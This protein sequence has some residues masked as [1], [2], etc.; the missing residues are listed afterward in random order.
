VTNRRHAAP[1]RRRI[2]SLRPLAFLAAGLIVLWASSAYGYWTASSTG[3]YALANAATLPSPTLSAASVTATSAALSWTQPFVPTGYALT[4]STGSLTGCTAAPA[5]GS[6]SCTATSLTPN[7]SYSWQLTASLY[8]WQAPATVS[9]TTAKQATTTALSNLT[10]TTGTAGASFSAT[11]TVTGNSGYGVPAGAVVFALYASSTCSGAASYTSSAQTL[12]G[13]AATG[14]L[15]PAV[16]TYYW[17]AVYSPTDTYNL[18]STSACSAAIT[19]TVA[20]ATFGGAGPPVGLTASANNVVVGYPAGTASGDLVLLVVSNSVSQD[21]VAPA[22]WTQIANPNLG[23]SSMELQAWWHKAGAETSVT[24]TKLQTSATGGTAWVL[25]YKNV[26]NPA[27]AGISS[28]TVAS[29]ASATPTNLTTTAA[30]ATVISLVGI[31]R[32]RSL[33]L[34][35][36]QGFSLRAALSNAIGNGNG[37]GVADTFAATAG[38]VT[39]PTWTE[40]ALTSQWAYITVAFT[41]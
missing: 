12:S 21:S 30:N 13:G 17:Q 18:A 27:V 36:A 10:P 23:G 6:T 39:S 38:S 35:T 26:T 33:S 5:V 22:G 8:N 29:A 7:T 9:A 34:Q 37:L 25:D 16:G 32:A 40:G 11:A 1:G 2:R 28:G 31:N 20:G 41:P 24:M 15:Q 4:Q 19:V 3:P 14:T